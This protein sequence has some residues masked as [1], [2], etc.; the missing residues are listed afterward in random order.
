LKD[1]VIHHPLGDKPPQAR[2][3]YGV[4]VV[5]G[6]RMLED[7]SIHT[8]CTSP[9]YWGLR[10]Y[11]TGDEQIGQEDTP[12]AFIE[13]LVNV[14]REAKRV[15]RSD[16]TLWLNLGDSYANDSKWGGTTGGKHRSDL[17]GQPVGRARRVTGLK[18][19]DMVGMPWR[20]ALALQEDGWYLRSAMPWV[21]RNCMP[22]S[23]K[24]RPSSAVEYIF[25]FAHPESG[26]R[27]YYDIH[28]FRAPLAAGSHTRL[29][30]ASFATQTGGG[31]GLRGN[32]CERQPLCPAWSGEPEGSLGGW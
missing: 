18:P 4:D 5:D 17:H 10:D 22:E 15:L 7:A 25:L 27:Y 19:K 12:E 1:T 3:I 26:G 13:G 31:E 8:I 20:V 23:C 32:R 6:L 21:K 2:L 16:G 24:D 9:P 14:F 29:N 30:Q 28:G 11:G